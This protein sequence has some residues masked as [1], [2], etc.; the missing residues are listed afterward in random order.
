MTE[1]SGGWCT[2][3]DAYNT[4]AIWQMIAGE[5]DPRGWR[6]VNAWGNF[7]QA[8][9]AQRRRLIA[10]RK[11]LVEKWPPE[12]SEA[13]RAF[14][15]QLDALIQSM[16]A[17]LAAASS[18]AR[19]LSGIMLALADAKREIEPIKNEYDE[20]SS[21]LI[22]RS[23]DDAEDELDQRARAVMS[24]A[25]RAVRDYTP[26]IK[27]P[28]PYRL[29]TGQDTSA[30]FDPNRPGRGGSGSGGGP[31]LDAAIPPVPHD[32]PAHRPGTEPVTP[33]G[34]EWV[35]TPPVTE[36]AGGA[37]PGLAAGPP[38]APGLPGGPGG[39][40]TVSPVSG[41]GGA[42]GPAGPGGGA[43]PPGGVIA[44]GAPGGVP[45]LP[46]AGRGA[47]RAGGARPGSA[48]TGR[49]GGARA[50]SAG[51]VIGGAP[52][53]PP[54]AGAGAAGRGARGRSAPGVP[55][56]SPPGGRGRGPVGREPVGLGGDP[57]N[58]WAVEEGVPPVIGPP[59]GERP[60]DPGQGVIGR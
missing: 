27:S 41:L 10:C 22:L 38:V 57:D 47:G 6:Q 18:T 53:V 21:D 32:P 52:A 54:G 5:D 31:G 11:S 55:G 59:D 39:P 33:G 58:P 29:R 13:S 49:A 44:P 42:G 7:E 46:A 23:W 25:E 40:G 1:T 2:N 8:V 30:P 24:R 35:A 48:G 14:V 15:Q 51:G 17:S 16:D 26:M 36:G 20:K 60:H 50:M 19:A 12:S 45:T 56:V 3:W 9:T 34:R 4:P 28:L 37:G 43:L